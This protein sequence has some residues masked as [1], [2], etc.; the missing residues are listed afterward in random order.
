M[1]KSKLMKFVVVVLLI[2]NLALIAFV[3][4]GRR[5]PAHEGPRDII[6]ERLHFNQKQVEEYDKMIT[7]HRKS[8][9]EMQAKMLRLKKSL[10]G[11]LIDNSTGS[12]DSLRTAIG[13]VQIEI[14]KINYDHFQD[15]RKLCDA[16]QQ[17]SFNLL[18]NDIAE[19]FR[20]MRRPGKK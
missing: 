18:V 19:L 13:N 14:E 8:I 9:D 1:N 15:I 5:R 6:I 7:G 2:S 12:N 11:T 4:S 10:Y 3:F 20:P 16:E 17:Q